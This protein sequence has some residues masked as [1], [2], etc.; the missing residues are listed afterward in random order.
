MISVHFLGKP[1]NMMVIEAY[2]PTSNAGEE[3]RYS[4]RRNK[5]AEPQWKQH[6]DVNVPGGET[7]V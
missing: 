5:E 7:K 2:V 1:F 6:P 4:S 3:W